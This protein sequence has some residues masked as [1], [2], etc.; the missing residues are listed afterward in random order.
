MSLLKSSHKTIFLSCAVL[1]GGID[2]ETVSSD[3]SS[4]R[5]GRPAFP[6]HCWM[7]FIMSLEFIMAWNQLPRAVWWVIPSLPSPPVSAVSSSPRPIPSLCVGSSYPSA[8]GMEHP[9]SGSG[10][11]PVMSVSALNPHLPSTEAGT[12][13]LLA[14]LRCF[15]W[16]REG[17]LMMSV[18]VGA[19]NN[20]DSSF[21]VFQE[22]ASP[23]FII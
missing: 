8:P 14:L 5:P 15:L 3:A 13:L 20:L 6:T 12:E 23:S 19:A 17:M 4:T 21:E 22:W 18:D 1:N 10:L 9:L 2:F 7:E 16:L 11:I